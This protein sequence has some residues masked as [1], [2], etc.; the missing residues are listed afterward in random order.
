MNLKLL[1][2]RFGPCLAAMLMCVSAPAWSDEFPMK[3]IKIVVTYPPGGGT[4]IT[5]RLIG[6]RLGE[7]LGQAVIVENKAGAGG[8]F[9]TEAVAKSA[10]DGYTLLLGNPGPNA[11][12][13]ALYSNLGYNAEKDF[14]PISVLTVMPLLLCVEVASPIKSVQDLVALGKSSDKKINFGSSGN[15]SLSHLAGEMFNSLAGTKFVHV[16]YKGAAPLTLATL[17]GEVQVG[18]LAGPDAYP[19]IKGGKLRAIGNTSIVRST[20]F[21]DVPTLKEAGIPGFDIEIWYG[22]LAP[23]KTPRPIVDRLHKELEK[24]LAEPATKDA[25]LAL[26]QT[27][28][29]NTPEQFSALIKSDIAKYARLVKL[30][31]AKVE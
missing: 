19:Q 5:A 12:N 15:G 25:L 11:I 1:G 7:N 23:A 30:S 24:I 2:R 26:S 10:P 18:L 8:S 6:K 28:A 31:G 20:S 29:A 13:P 3:P 4:D 21:P 14:A 27:A 16:P 9:G 17:T 22:L